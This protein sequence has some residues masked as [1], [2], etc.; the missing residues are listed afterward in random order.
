MKTLEDQAAEKYPYPEYHKKFGLNTEQMHDRMLQTQI[1]D[2]ERTAYIAGLKENDWI[3]IEKAELVRG[4]EFFIAVR[5]KNKADGIWL[6]DKAIFDEEG[7]WIQI[8]TWEKI[9]YV[10]TPT[11][12]E[13]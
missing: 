12:P 5:N 2:R 7:N 8:D 1:I 6:Y 3:P 4:E 13:Q 10:K 9:L 11:P